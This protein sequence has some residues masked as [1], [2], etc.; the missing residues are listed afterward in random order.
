MIEKILKYVSDNIKMN[1]KLSSISE[2]VKDLSK[3]V[4]DI[5]CRLIR[6]ETFIDLAKDKKVITLM[7][8]IEHA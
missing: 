4:K 6:V 7:K 8:E 1:E 5:D 3:E 2:K